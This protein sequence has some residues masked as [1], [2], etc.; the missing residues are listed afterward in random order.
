MEFSLVVCLREELKTESVSEN[1]EL[2]EVFA[3]TREEENAVWRN[4]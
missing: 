3:L 2:R 4:F 1:S